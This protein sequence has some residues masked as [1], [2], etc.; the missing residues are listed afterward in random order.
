MKFGDAETAYILYIGIISLG[1]V[2]VGVFAYKLVVKKQSDLKKCPFCAES[3]QSK[4]IVCRFCGR[5]LN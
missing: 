2:I 4:A 1:I 3:I 5:D